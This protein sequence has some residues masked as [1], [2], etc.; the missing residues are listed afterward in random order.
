V[1]W[2]D[3][4]PRIRAENQAWMDEFLPQLRER[5]AQKAAKRGR[6][7]AILESIENDEDRAFILNYIGL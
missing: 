2:R 5:D 6:A 1:S 3:D 4:L 7:R